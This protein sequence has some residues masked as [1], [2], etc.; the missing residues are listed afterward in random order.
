MLEH[1]QVARLLTTPNEYTALTT[2]T[3]PAFPTVGV[4]DLKD[5]RDRTLLYGYT[6]DR[7]TFHVYLQN[8]MM[9]LVLYTYEGKCLFHLG[10]N[11]GEAFAAKELVPNKRLYPE[12]CDHE[13]CLLLKNLGV[14]LPFT[15]FNPDRPVATWYGKRRLELFA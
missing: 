10:L 11:A 15:T 5:R 13:T 14:S 12:A 4:S 9:H 1:P 3:P 7:H 8:D 2:E 6:S